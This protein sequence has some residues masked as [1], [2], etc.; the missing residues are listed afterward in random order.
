MVSFHGGGFAT[1]SGSGPQYD[2]LQL[3]RLADA[4]VV[5]RGGMGSAWT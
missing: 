4:V 1:G 2:G 3:A 5:D